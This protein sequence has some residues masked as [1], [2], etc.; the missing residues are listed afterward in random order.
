M[1]VIVTSNS[2]VIVCHERLYDKKKSHLV[3]ISRLDDRW[4]K[5][6]KDAPLDKVRLLYVG[7]MSSEKGIFDFL[8]MF[9][10]IKFDAQF[11]IVGDARGKNIANKII[12][13]HRYKIFSYYLRI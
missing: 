10:K 1:Y 5:D 2:K 9:N 8:K 12:F 13:L 7:R 4:L 6:R 11:S 3:R